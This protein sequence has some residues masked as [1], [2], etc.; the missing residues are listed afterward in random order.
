MITRSIDTDEFYRKV[1]SS[2]PVGEGVDYFVKLK[3][4][5][6]FKA[7]LGSGIVTQVRLDP[8]EISKEDY[9]SF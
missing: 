7:V 9:Q 4:K 5:P 8:V 2:E 3:G 6:E 1:F